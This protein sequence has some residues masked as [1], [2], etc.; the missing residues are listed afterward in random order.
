[1]FLN[2]NLNAYPHRLMSIGTSFGG[3]ICEGLGDVD[4]FEKVSHW[5]GE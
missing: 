1:M 2:E 3:I 5:G 4:L